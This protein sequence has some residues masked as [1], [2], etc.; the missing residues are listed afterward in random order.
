VPDA[1][2]HAAASLGAPEAPIGLHSKFEARIV[3]FS[4]PVPLTRGYVAS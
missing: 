3:T 4:L 1:L 2:P